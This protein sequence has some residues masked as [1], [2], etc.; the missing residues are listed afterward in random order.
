MNPVRSSLLGL[1]FLAVGLLAGVGDPRP[2]R[3]D[4]PA[5]PHGKFKEECSHCHSPKSWTPARIGPE[6]DHARYGLPL[7][8]AHKET[9]CRSCH[10][11]LD[12]S[13]EA[14]ECVECHQDVHEGELGTECAGCH[15]T[16]S[17]I[18]R[19]RMERMHQLTRFPLTGVHV[20]LDCLSCHGG[21][22]GGNLSFVNLASECV[23]CHREAGQSAVPDH[24]ENL[25]PEDCTLCHTTKAWIPARFGHTDTG[26]PIT[27]A[28]RNLACEAC[29][30]QGQFT[31]VSALCVDC[32]RTDYDGTQDPDHNALG[33]A[34]ECQ[35][36][37][38]TTS[39]RGAT[40]DHDGSFFPIYSGAHAGKWESCTTCHV[41][42]A[43]YMDFSCFGCHPH[44]D[45]TKTDGDHREVRDY[46]YDS[47]ACYTCHPRGRH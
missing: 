10:A 46:T 41:N 17:F 2:S 38:N 24:A 12:F 29:H 45:R 40:F 22:G 27:G 7:V 39:W 25:F 20:T 33:F 26:F 19:S 1:V 14:S 30:G 47:Q 15:T 13:R 36:C 6:F 35:S 44:D 43:D 32:H 9:P 5:N 42:A 31:K 16:R 21:S 8:G 4:V 3:A 11:S 23:S 28:H 18:D 37:H 34:L